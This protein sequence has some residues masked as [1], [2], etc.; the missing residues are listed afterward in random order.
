MDIHPDHGGLHPRV[1]QDP[2]LLADLPCRRPHDGGVVRLDV[3]SWLEPSPKPLVEHERHA[4]GVRRQNDPTGG[5][6][7]RV[8]LPSPRRI[9]GGPQQRQDRL[10]AGLAPR[11]GPGHEPL[12]PAADLG[13]VNQ[14]SLPVLRARSPSTRTAKETRAPETKKPRGR[15]RVFH[16]P[17]AIELR[18]STDRRDPSDRASSWRRM[19]FSSKLLNDCAK[20]MSHVEIV[21]STSRGSQ[22]MSSLT[23]L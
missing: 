17:S 18:R 19:L 22:P 15:L 6:V 10:P 3:S 16:R 7:A 12:S 11:I 23:C 4:T 1:Y 13:Q 9:R 5:D 21:P 20:V 14:T 8:V 2:S